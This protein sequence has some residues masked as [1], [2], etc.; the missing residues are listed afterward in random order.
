MRN[1]ASKRG[2]TLVELIVVI[3]IIG[4]L[5]AVL[6][7]TFSGAIES[8][9]LASD[10]SKVNA[11]NTYLAMET[12]Q[13]GNPNEV[14]DLKKRLEEEYDITLTTESRDNYLWYDET[15]NRVVL[16]SVQGALT[17][18]PQ[19]ASADE[20]GY[21]PSE[22]LFAPEKFAKNYWFLNTEG[23]AFVQAVNAFRNVQTDTTKEDLLAD[24]EAVKEVNSTVYAR[25]KSLMERSAF[26]TADG[27]QKIFAEDKAEISNVIFN[28][29]VTALTKDTFEGLTN[30]QVLDI[31]ASVTSVAG[32]TFETYTDSS[33]VIVCYSEET[34]A[35]VDPAVAGKENLLTVMGEERDSSTWTVTFDAGEGLLQNGDSQ[36]VMI[37]PAANRSSAAVSVPANPYK[38]SASESDTYTFTGWVADNGQTNQGIDYGTNSA[39]VNENLGNNVVFTAQYQTGGAAMA[40]VFGQPIEETAAASARALGGMVANADGGGGTDPDDTEVGYFADLADAVSCA[41]EFGHRNGTEYTIVLTAGQH[42]QNRDFVI[43]ANVTLVIPEDAE[44]RTIDSEKLTDDDAAMNIACYSSLSLSEGV[45]VS[46]YGGIGT[47]AVLK[48]VSVGGQTHAGEI[49]GGYGEIIIGKNAE[50]IVEDG[51]NFTVYGEVSGEGSL[52]VLSGGNV[53]ETM[54]INDWRGGSNM[55]ACTQDDKYG[56]LIFPFNNY[57]LDRIDLGQFRINYGATY[58]AYAYAYMSLQAQITCPMVGTGALFELKEGGYILKSLDHSVITGDENYARLVMDVYGGMKD[59]AAVVEVDAII[60]TSAD[61]EK[62]AF[63]VSFMEIILNDGDYTLSACMYKFLPGSILRIKEDAVLTLGREVI[64]YDTFTYYDKDVPSGK[65]PSSRKAAQFLVEGTLKIS[66]GTEVGGS[67]LAS[68]EHAKMI[69]ETGAVFEAKFLEG[70]ATSGNISAE[71]KEIKTTPIP[72][73]IL[74]AGEEETLLSAGTFSAVQEEDGWVWQKQAA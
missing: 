57:R 59:N 34:K 60:S 68:G 71:I 9:R 13:I 19:G 7:P 6:I 50:I 69:V 61:L 17:G 25:M 22:Y 2:F 37:L 29:N 38:L 49:Q 44:A 8:A 45:T 21:G 36:K 73:T 14:L 70:Y 43:P 18:F 15:Q 26:V 48:N 72:A 63:P 33:V 51:G 5:A 30:V 42:T 31:P 54:V 1:R 32:D 52:T 47:N 35:A 3:A 55:Y 56:E 20:G 41:V 12:I 11:I 23:N 39:I 62:M 65:Y 46:I 74:T 64:V 16:G 66:S 27:A 53:T 58:S 10:K 24:L 40:F 4:I 28:P 67:F